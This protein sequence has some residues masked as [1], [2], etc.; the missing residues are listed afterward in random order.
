MSSVGESRAAASDACIAVG[1]ESL[2]DELD[3]FLLY[4][5]GLQCS[6]YLKQIIPCD[7]HM[8]CVSCPILA[9]YRG[10]GAGRYALNVHNSG[11][12]GSFQTCRLGERYFA[13]RYVQQGERPRRHTQ[14]R[15]A[16]RPLRSQTASHRRAA[17]TMIHGERPLRPT[18]LGH[19]RRPLRPQRISAMAGRNVSAQGAQ[20]LEIV[21]AVTLLN[22]CRPGRLN[23]AVGS[24][25]H[26]SGR[27]VLHVR[28]V[29]VQWSGRLVGSVVIVHIAAPSAP[30]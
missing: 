29:R 15:H 8:H 19:D 13:G 3:I 14:V 2:R 6:L 23:G 28:M 11:A 26:V 30:L 20:R 12:A 1:P 22:S 27:A 4:D 21:P 16:G 7:T 17:V 25:I 10:M 18:P 9:K 24:T 5:Y